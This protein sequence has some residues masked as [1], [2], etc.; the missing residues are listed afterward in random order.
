VTGLRQGIALP[1]GIG[2]HAMV[3]ATAAWGGALAGAAGGLWLGVGLV[4]AGI[5]AATTKRLL[6]GVLICGAVLSGW[7][8]AVRVEA[9]L[10]AELIGGPVRLRGVIA[11]EP[12]PGNPGAVFLF[13]ADCRVEGDVCVA[14]ALPPVGVETTS[15]GGVTAGDR[16]EIAGELEPRPGRLRGDPIAGRVVDAAVA[17]LQSPPNLLFGAGNALRLH[18]VGRLAGRSPR[19]ATALMAGLL[20]GD[21]SA[22]SEDDL[23]ALRRSGLTHFVAVSGSNVALFLVAWWAVSA[24]FLA[25]PRLRSLWGLVG[26]ALFVVVTR[27][28][29]SVVRASTM[30]GLVLVGRAVA[31]PIDAWTALGVAITCLLLVSGDLATNVGFQL[32]VAATAGVLA[33][34]RAFAGRRPRWFWAALGATAAAQLA[35]TPL[36]LLHFGTVPLLSPVAN[37]L[38]AP[39][40]MVATATGGVGAVAGVDPLLT[41]GLVAAKGV[42]A[43]AHIAGD[44]P[45]LGWTEVA[46]LAGLGWSL[47]FRL[48]RP[49]VVAVMLVMVVPAVG[50][51]RAPAVATVT[52]LDVGQGDAILVQGNRG[53]VVLIDGGRDPNVLRDKLRMRNITHLDIVIVSHGDDD[54]LGGLI[55]L[56]GRLEIGELWVPDQPQASGAFDS[57]VAAAGGAGIPVR[58]VRAPSRARWG[59]IAVV[60]LGPRRRYAAANDGSVVVLLHAGGR[61]MLLAG[62]IEAVAQRDIDPVP[63]DVLLV[64]HHGSATSDLEWLQAIAPRLAV[65]S[66]GPNRYGHPSPVVLATLRKSGAEVLT[67]RGEGDIVVPFP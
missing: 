12:V 8:A 51:Y 17:R 23:D 53:E 22:M 38:A 30:A 42:L 56:P 67:T 21:T 32:S 33:G 27:W 57:F 60:V 54:H 2:R 29:A 63:I 15:P 43:V 24:P 39:L 47:R 1:Q 40:V 50:P 58:A 44:W 14:V 62:D 19:P 13:R 25:D 9:T 5:V 66:V 49:A 48:V 35:V 64:P 55:G 37:V 20:I 10:G 59:D 28:E 61:S 16:V 31:V 52:V 34:A 18:V 3:A 45:Q 46:L 41:I 65:V 36:L 11:D 26:L 7:L 4:V 6:L